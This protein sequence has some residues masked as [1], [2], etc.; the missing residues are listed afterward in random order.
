MA[1][2]ALDITHGPHVKENDPGQISR[3]LRQ[4]REVPTAHKPPLSLQSTQ[5]SYIIST[6]LP[7]LTLPEMVTIFAV[8]GD[9][10]KI[11]AD[12]W[13]MEENCEYMSIFSLFEFDLTSFSLCV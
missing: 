12:A 7:M 1:V 3:Q 13:H 9:R 11:V 10:L 6:K 5:S 8:K 4:R 2:E